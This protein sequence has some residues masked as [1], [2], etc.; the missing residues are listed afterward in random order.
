LV[1]RP[2]NFFLCT[3]VTA[4]LRLTMS[5]LTRPTLVRFLLLAGAFLLSKFLLWSATPDVEIVLSTYR[6]DPILVAQQINL[7][8]GVLATHGWSSRVTVY[9]KDESLSL[10]EIEP[11]LKVLGADALTLLPNRGRE[12]GTLCVAL[13]A[14]PITS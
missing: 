2:T 1:P 7:L 10:D 6:E 4:I 3:T 8:R 12:G 13:T 5:D 11:L 9:S 14:C